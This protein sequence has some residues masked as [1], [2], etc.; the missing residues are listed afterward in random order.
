MTIKH[1]RLQNSGT[2]ALNRIITESETLHT[3]NGIPIRQSGIEAILGDEKAAIVADP[4]GSEALTTL[5]QTSISRASVI[6]S[7]NFPLR[8]IDLSNCNL[9]GD[10]T[11]MFL[12][13]VCGNSELTFLS[14]RGNHLQ[15]C[16][17]Y[18]ASLIDNP[19]LTEFAPTC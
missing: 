15:K 4:I 18:L 3:V 13:A 1:V 11:D 5:L 12:S 10:A 19:D 9:G 8:R 2:E 7:P 16:P 17:P 14:L 6:L